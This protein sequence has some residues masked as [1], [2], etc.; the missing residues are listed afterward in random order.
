[1]PISAPGS[2]TPDS[3]APRDSSTSRSLSP[4]T[5]GGTSR[6]RPAPE[7]R[8]DR[9][10]ALDVLANRFQQGYPYLCRVTDISR[11]GIR[12]YTF[13][14][15]EL[16][17][18]HFSGL[19]FQLPGS[20]NLITAS[21]VVVFEDATAGVVGIRF[22]HLSRDAGAAIEGYLASYVDRARAT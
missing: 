21:G 17:S 6:N 3:C 4:S 19:Q 20:P 1:M 11:K 7:R 12:L 16:P 18:R 8:R 13:N 15:P 14:E 22:L 5:G 2:P 9:R 10:V